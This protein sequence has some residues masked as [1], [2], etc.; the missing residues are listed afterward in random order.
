[1]KVQ[2]TEEQYVNILLKECGLL[3]E[4]VFSFNDMTPEEKQQSYEIFKQSYEKTTGNSWSEMKF[5]SRARNWTFYG[6]KG[7]GFVTVRKQYD[8]G[9]KV[10]GVAGDM[11]SVVVGL[12]D[13]E[14]VDA[15][16]WGMA[17]KRMVGLL[18]KKFSYFTPPAGMAKLLIGFIPSAEFGNAAVK[19]N[20]DGSA[21]FTYDD[22]GSA[23]KFFFANSLYYEKI[24]KMVDGKLDG[25]V[26]PEQ[27]EEI[28]TFLAQ[29]I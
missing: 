29:F 22:V 26:A 6:I 13:L 3:N 20:D 4:D 21:T 16:V 15:P 5:F 25:F 23:T 17:E 19:I 11:G 1:M 12:N 28:E 2:I 14:N 10:T 7:K 8:G 24:A 27:K 18:T 9:S